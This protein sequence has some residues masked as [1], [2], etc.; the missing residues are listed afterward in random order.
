MVARIIG[1]AEYTVT[2]V[3]Q[4]AGVLVLGCTRGTDTGI[5]DVG[6]GI[7]TGAGTARGDDKSGSTLITEIVLEA[8]NAVIEG[9]Q[10]AGVVVLHIICDADTGATRKGSELFTDT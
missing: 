2:N 3:T 7:V 9:A 5:V 1:L 6:V 10:V 8:R 4:V